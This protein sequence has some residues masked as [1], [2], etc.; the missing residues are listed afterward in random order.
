[1]TIKDIESALADLTD[2]NS[3]IFM[4]F[5]NFLKSEIRLN[6]NQVQLKVFT[7]MC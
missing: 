3:D 7:I 2:A 4:L 5:F 6:M 1:M